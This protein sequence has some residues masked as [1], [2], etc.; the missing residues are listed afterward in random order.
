M[1]VRLFLFVVFCSLNI[2]YGI[3]QKCKVQGVVRYEFNDYVGYKVDIGAE[4]KFIAKEDADSLNVLH[5]DEYEKLAKKQSYHLIMKQSAEDSYV[6]EDVIRSFSGFSVEDEA[7]L[8]EL[9]KICL[10]EYVKGVS[11]SSYVGLVDNSGKYEV[12]IPYGEYYV[13]AKSANRER[14]TVTELTG[15]VIFKLVKIDKPVKILSFD[16]DY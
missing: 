5:W 13:I 12:E 4:I 1:K 11:L 9:D 3:A 16:F 14:S 2:T 8:K 10:I 6:G 7:R 15:R